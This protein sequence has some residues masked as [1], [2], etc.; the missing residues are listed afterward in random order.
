MNYL[1]YYSKKLLT[2]TLLLVLAS[3]CK[4]YSELDIEPVETGNADFSTYVAVGNSLTAGYQNDALYQSAQE[5]S[6]PNLIARQVNQAA[7]FSQPLISNPGSGGRIELVSLEPLVTSRNSSQGQ[8]INQQEKPFS[9]LGVPGAVLV[10]YLNPQNSGH[11]KERATNPEHPAFNPFYSIIMEDAEL[12]KEAPNLHNQVAKQSPTFISFWLGNNDV[13]GFVTSGGEGQSI[14]PPATFKQ[15][16]QGS[17]Q[18]MASTGA[19]VAVYTIPNVTSIPFVFYLRT[20]LEQQG[21]IAFNSET[22]S[23]QLATPE[24]SFDIYIETDG[25]PRVMRQSDFPILSAQAY[26]GKI[27]AGEAPLPIMPQDAIPD[28]L[29]LDGPAGG[30]AGSSELEQAIGAIQR[31]NAA[32]ANIASSSGFALVD[33]N[34]IFGEI[35]ANFQ[36]SGGTKGYQT[37]GITLRPVPGELFSFDGVHPTSRGSAVLANESIKAINQTFGANIPAINVAKI[38]EGFPVTSEA[39]ASLR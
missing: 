26:F 25:G 18:A 13:L 15:L 38:P 30:P 29:V 31:Y 10:D 20:Q 1:T 28:E 16:Y 3:S 21:A 37:D 36:E 14:T 2:L 34:D 6:F 8:P 23:Y 32:I 12:A 19:N 9:N 11:L 27:Q 4:D 24:G 17:A 5:F 22:Q 35:F 33:I 39:S 7:S